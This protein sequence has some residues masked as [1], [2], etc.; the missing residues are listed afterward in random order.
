MLRHAV[1]APNPTHGPAIHAGV[2]WGDNIL[3]FEL[4]P[5][6]TDCVLTM[7]ATFDER[8]RGA[9]DLDA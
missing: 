7:T 3:R 9:R 5:E 2:P 8:G 1:P 6:G 4:R